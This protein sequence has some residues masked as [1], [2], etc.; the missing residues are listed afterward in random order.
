MIDFRNR[1][2]NSVSWRGLSYSPKDN[3]RP[4]LHAD[5]WPGDIFYLLEE[6]DDVRLDMRCKRIEAP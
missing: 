5:I 3:G 6:M 1:N 4:L 2:A